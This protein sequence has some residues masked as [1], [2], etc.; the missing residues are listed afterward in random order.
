MRRS[1]I[2]A[3]TTAC[4]ALVAGVLVVVGSSEGGEQS[5]KER[6][7]MKRMVKVY[8]T[9]QDRIVEVEAI[10]K[11]DREW[12]KV[13]SDEAF[14]VTRKHDTERAFSGTYWNHKGEGVYRCAACGNDLFLSTS[15]FESGTGWPSYTEPVHDANVGTKADRSLFFLRTEVHCS[16][17]K[18]HL[19][20]V[21]D[22][23]PKPTGMRYCINSAALTFAELE[24]E[25]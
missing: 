4:I 5:G 12:M 15:K 17:C 7:A 20:H 8:S 23:G 3:V 14:R 1:R 16:R 6:T 11:T 22:D 18:A 24:L 2:E 19:G 21:F 10:E 13:L 9:E 25:E